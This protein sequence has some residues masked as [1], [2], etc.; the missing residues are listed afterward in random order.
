[1]VR[2]QVYLTKNESEAISRLSYILQ[3]GK[4][5]LI[6]TAIDEFIE[7]R[8]TKNKL[9][10]LRAARGMWANRTDIPDVKKMRSEFDRF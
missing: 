6:R 8:E 2:T 5:E 9:K 4:S 7:R 3:Q 1:M 10:K